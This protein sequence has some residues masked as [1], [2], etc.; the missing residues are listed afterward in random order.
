MNKVFYLSCFI[1]I[2]IVNNSF[3]QTLFGK[4]QMT[5]AAGLYSVT[6]DFFENNRFTQKIHSDLD[7]L[8]GAGY[9]ILDNKTFI[10]VYDE[11][12]NSNVSEYQLIEGNSTKDVSNQLNV[13]IVVRDSESN[14]E[15]FAGVI[16]QL[17]QNKTIVLNL[18]TDNG[19]RVIFQINNTLLI[20][21]ITV[22]TLGY[23]PIFI[24]LN[25]IKSSKVK[26]ECFLKMNKNKQIGFKKIQYKIVEFTKRVLVITNEKETLV[27]RKM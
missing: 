27:L 8:Q 9:Y 20:N 18:I 5:D 23:E 7:S 25:D 17:D 24:S 10:L 19:G 11:V 13:E 15:L 26:I 6:F 14:N 2:G 21:G 22:F 16:V 4:Y 12:E 3:C 1:V